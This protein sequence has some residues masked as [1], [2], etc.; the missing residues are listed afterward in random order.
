M[1][2][3]KVLFLS[4][5]AVHP[6]ERSSGSLSDFF[7]PWRDKWLFAAELQRRPVCVFFVPLRI[8]SSKIQSRIVSKL[9]KDEWM[10]RRQ[11]KRDDASMANQFGKVLP[12][13]RIGWENFQWPLLSSCSPFPF[14]GQESCDAKKLKQ[15]SRVKKRCKQEGGSLTFSILNLS[16]TFI[17]WQDEKVALGFEGHCSSIS[18]IKKK[19]EGLLSAFFLISLLSWMSSAFSSVF[20]L[21][22]ALII[23]LIH[24]M[25]DSR[26]GPKEDKWL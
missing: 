24:L 26:M 12:P 4:Y 14:R 5:P 3:H 15:K 1:Y 25:A 13:W 10:G 11:E 16:S 17:S 20:R 22:F 18:V 21:C 19:L 9:R 7:F 2:S 23:H 6:V 8:L